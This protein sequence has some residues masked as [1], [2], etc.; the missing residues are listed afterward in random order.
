MTLAPRGPAVEVLQQ[1]EV[2]T[3][4]RLLVLAEAPANLLPRA[5]VQHGPQGRRLDVDGVLEAGTLA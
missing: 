5:E 1:R 3:N 2:L 4:G